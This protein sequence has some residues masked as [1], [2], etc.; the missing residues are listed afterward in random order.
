V[1]APPSAVLVTGASGLVGRRLLERLPR[2]LPGLRRAVALDRRPP[3]AGALPD[4]V[5][6]ERGD[7]RDAALAALLERHGI[8]AVVHLAAV[9]APGPSSTREL[10]YDIDVN[11]TRNVLQACLGSGVRHL[12]ALSSGAAYG[13]HAD[14]PVP[15]REEDPLRGNRAFAY[16]WHKR[17]VE[18]MLAEARETHPELAQLVLRPGTILAAGVSSPVTA[19]FERR[20]VLGVAG[21][22]APFVLISDEDVAAC[23]ARGLREGSTGVYNLCGDGAI[24]LRDIARRM[25]RP[26]LPL[27]ARWLAAALAMLKGLRLSSRGPEQVDF[28][29]YRPVL[30]NELLKRELGFVPSASSE[31]CFER[32][33]AGRG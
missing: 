19:L 33:R 6:F 9:V 30:S 5:A 26:Y 12:V 24:S 3:A 17:L 7:V 31:E 29:R 15:L 23:I 10:E 16:A 2:E 18:E 27:P 1:P 22:E 13:Y 14:N 8:E 28:L 32:W 20:V 21:A 11:G 25:G 4:G